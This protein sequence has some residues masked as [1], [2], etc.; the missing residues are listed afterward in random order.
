MLLWQYCWPDALSLE[1]AVSIQKR[2]GIAGTSVLADVYLQLDVRNYSVVELLSPTRRVSALLL[3]S[4]F[5]VRDHDKAAAA[6]S[7]L[8][9]GLESGLGRYEDYLYDHP[10]E[11]ANNVYR[12]FA[13][14]KHYTKQEWEPRCDDL[15]CPLLRFRRLWSVVARGMPLGSTMQSR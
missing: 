13:M 4:V 9:G 1:V 10:E 2:H 5:L 3:D 12:V 7:D 15:K 6:S 11:E 8:A 14:T